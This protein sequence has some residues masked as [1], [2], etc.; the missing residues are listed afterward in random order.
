VPSASLSDCTV[1]AL[2]AKPNIL[3]VETQELSRSVGCLYFSFAKEIKHLKDLESN[4]SN[5]VVDSASQVPVLMT[6]ILEV[7]VRTIHPALKCDCFLTD[8][9]RMTIDLARSL[10]LYCIGPSCPAISTT[11]L[12]CISNIITA[13]A[14][15]R[16]LP[17]CTLS[18]GSL[19]ER[20]FQIRLECGLTFDWDVIDRLLLDVFQ[21]ES[22]LPISKELFYLAV[23]KL[24]DNDAAP[25][26][27]QVCIHIR[28]MNTSF[29]IEGFSGAPLGI[30]TPRTANSRS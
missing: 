3:T 22:D 17:G 8:I 12:Q 23:K 27:M 21:N 30:F 2:F 6:V 5:I 7:A 18:I 10:L 26:G 29:L 11:R 24:G 13:T 16:R 4:P 1:I 14:A 15:L 28:L 9:F 20:L 25:H 19:P